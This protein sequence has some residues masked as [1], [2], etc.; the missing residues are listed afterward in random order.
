MSK[1]EPGKSRPGPRK[2]KAKLNK[3]YTSTKAEKVYQVDSPIEVKLGETVEIRLDCMNGFTVFFPN[4]V[5]FGD[6][7][8]QA[9]DNPSWGAGEPAPEHKW[10]GVRLTRTNIENPNVI[11]EKGKKRE[12]AYCIYSKD[13]DNFAVGNSPPKMILDP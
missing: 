12:M 4:A 10:W 2:I 8:F 6:H 7:V 5:F 1:E 11:K 9:D 3:G 13:L